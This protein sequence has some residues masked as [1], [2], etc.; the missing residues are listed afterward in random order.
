M[1][2]CEKCRKKCFILLSVSFH[3]IYTMAVFSGSVL[4]KS[5]TAVV[6]FVF[7]SVIHVFKQSGR[8]LQI[9]VHKYTVV[10]RPC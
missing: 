5:C 3:I 8:M 4:S 2:I 9:G 6:S 7:D 1:R 10:S